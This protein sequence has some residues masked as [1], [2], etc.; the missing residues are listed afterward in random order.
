MFPAH[1]AWLPTSS[2][3]VEDKMLSLQIDEIIFGTYPNEYM[4]NPQS[5]KRKAVEQITEPLQ[6][7]SVTF[8]KQLLVAFEFSREAFQLF[9]T[10]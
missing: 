5:N 3:G 8:S 6:L 4:Q 10:L 1:G 7:C 2:I 9:K